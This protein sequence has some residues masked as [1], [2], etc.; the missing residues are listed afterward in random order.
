MYMYRVTCT[1]TWKWLLI[2]TCI[3]TCIGLVSNVHPYLFQFQY[4]KILIK[5]YLIKHFCI[6]CDCKNVTDDEICTN[7]HVHVCMCIIHI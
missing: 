7:V 6:L 1:R 2:L 5:L 4:L 3:L